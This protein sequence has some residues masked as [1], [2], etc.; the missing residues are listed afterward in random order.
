MVFLYLKIH[1]DPGFG[2]HAEKAF[3]P[4]NTNNLH[5]YVKKVI[6]DK[7]INTKMKKTGLTGLFRP[8][9]CNKRLMH[10]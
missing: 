1:R 6:D 4:K 7:Y 2:Y 8:L 9:G 10:L 5:L 3:Y